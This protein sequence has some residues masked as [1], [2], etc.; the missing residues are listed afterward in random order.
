MTRQRVRNLLL[1][2]LLSILLCAPAS[3]QKPIPLPELSS[4]R[5][6]NDLEIAV[7]AAP[8]PDDKMTIG[9]ALRYGAAFDPSGKE[10]LAHLLSRL[11]LKGTADMTAKGIQ[12]ELEYLGATIDILCDWTGY[13]FLM[14]APSASFERSL[15]LLYQV[16]CEA[17]LKEADMDAV[18]KEISAGLEKPADPRQR[19]H[20]QFENT[21]FGGTTYGR[22]IQGTRKSLAAITLGDVRAFYRKFFSPNQAFLLVVGNVPARIVLQKATRIW[23]A[24]VRNDIIPFSFKPP[25]RLTERRI[26]LEDDPASPAAQFIMGNLFPRREETAYLPALMAAAIL[27]ERLTK[28]LPTSLLTV[29]I[30]GRRLAS[31]FYVQG[32]AAA[33][34]AVEQIRSIQNA[35]A[36]MKREL[37]SPEELN[38][39]QNR[40][41]EDF[42]RELGTN[43]GLCRI[44]LEAELYY[45][46]SNYASNFPAMVMRCDAEEIRRASNSWLFPGA[47]IILVRGPAA[48]LKPALEPLGQ[49][50]PMVP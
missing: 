33:E 3:A 26:L 45:L 41:I 39:V 22:P 30:Q 12:D 44:M 1:C 27:Q 37:V 21:L 36:E 15:L 11:F 29:G 46:G 20:A 48:V 31:P 2:V 28:L 42:R 32:Q 35:A 4:K 5:L 18:R 50:K 10:G 13:R 40:L 49:V 7:A 24:W 25:L 47:E 8:Q 14:Q 9:L 19:I 17:E 43:E 34:Q 38:L 16:V 23:G 6:L